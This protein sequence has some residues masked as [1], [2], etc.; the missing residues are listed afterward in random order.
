MTIRIIFLGARELLTKCA[1]AKEQGA[2]FTL[3][4][5]PSVRRRIGLPEHLSE[6]QERQIRGAF[7]S[8]QAVAIEPPRLF[9]VPPDAHESLRQSVCMWMKAPVSP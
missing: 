3:Q 1:I 5:W 8:G 7:Q 2:A 4:S 9:V 6:V